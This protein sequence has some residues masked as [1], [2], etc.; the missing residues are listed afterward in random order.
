MSGLI[1]ISSML[2]TGERGVYG[3]GERAPRELGGL[4]RELVFPSRIASTSL[5]SSSSI[6]SIDIGC[7]AMVGGVVVL[8]DGL[9]HTRRV[10]R[11]GGVVGYGCVVQLG[12][13]FPIG[14]A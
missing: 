2:R 5:R 11:F 7:L 1:P 8:R 9:S 10:G 4:D 6:A 14:V 12:N 13:Q 3:D